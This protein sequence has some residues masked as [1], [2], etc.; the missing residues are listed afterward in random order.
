M[1]VLMQRLANSA[2][3][4]EVAPASDFAAGWLVP[5]GIADATVP[6]PLFNLAPAQSVSGDGRCERTDSLPEQQLIK[7]TDIG[8]DRMRI[9]R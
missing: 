9:H 6:N 7:I 3:Y 1:R 5:P 2:R 4:W 8:T